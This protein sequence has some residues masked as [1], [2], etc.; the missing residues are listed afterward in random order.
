M[1]EKGNCKIVQDLLPNYIE[2]LT[3]KETNQYVYDHLEECKECKT[4]LENMQKELKVDNS[5]S[6]RGKVKYLKKYQSKLMIL[7][8]IVLLILIVFSIDIVRKM[9]I[10]SS[11]DK[12]ATQ[13]EN[14][15]NYHVTRYSYSKDGYSKSENYSIG[16]KKKLIVTKLTETEKSIL[17]IYSY[18][19]IENQ[20]LEEQT[21]SKNYQSHIYIDNKEG[22]QVQ[23]NGRVTIGKIVENPMHTEN[24][25]HLFLAA[26][27][28]SVTSRNY[29]GKDCYFITNYKT[30]SMG[31]SEEVY[32]DKETGLVAGRIQNKVDELEGFAIEYV[33]EFNTVTE[34]DFIEPDREEYEEITE[35]P[36]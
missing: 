11:M 22:R 8:M 20:I 16:D 33:Y 9:I 27:T 26:I 35:L 24:L 21:D 13:Y 15:T 36:R 4:I 3:N 17:Q 32:I 28:S 18:E 25:C 12:K 23:L 1:N 30:L 5:K 7:R 10:I 6:E 29:N 19:P 31:Y 34:N 14:S 2:K